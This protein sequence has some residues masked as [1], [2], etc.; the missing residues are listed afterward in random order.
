MM[1]TIG[2]MENVTYDEFRKWQTYK[3]ENQL[4]DNLYKIDYDHEFTL[5]HKRN[6]LLLLSKNSKYSNWTFQGFQPVIE[7]REPYDIRMGIK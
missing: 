7:H 5:V 1:E 6:S 4:L 2:I 3:I